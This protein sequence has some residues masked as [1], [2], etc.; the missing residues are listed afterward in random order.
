MRLRGDCYHELLDDSS[1]SFVPIPCHS[2]MLQASNSS[3]CRH[4][5]GDKRW[6]DIPDTGTDRVF[7]TWGG[8][9]CRAGYGS[10]HSLLLKVGVP[11]RRGR[12][13]PHDR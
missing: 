9:S 13:Y 12:V 11:I 4:M 8:Y 10:Y 7:P 6:H 3:R 1:Y 2:Q 5:R